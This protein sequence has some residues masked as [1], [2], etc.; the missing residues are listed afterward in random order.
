MLGELIMEVLTAYAWL[1]R[2]LLG[3]LLGAILYFEGVD[4]NWLS[5]WL[6]LTAVWELSAWF[7]YK[8]W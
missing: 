8:K 6:I 5:F 7:T 1:R 3:G 4:L 2:L